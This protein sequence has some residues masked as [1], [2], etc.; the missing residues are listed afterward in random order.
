MAKPIQLTTK[1][2]IADVAMAASE[3]A[4]LIIRP[5]IILLAKKCQPGPAGG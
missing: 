2:E 5:P 4:A 1:T 3:I